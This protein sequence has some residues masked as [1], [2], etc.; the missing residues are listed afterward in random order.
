MTNI[1][2]RQKPKMI[3]PIVSVADDL[4]E[5]FTEAQILSWKSIDNETIDNEKISAM[6]N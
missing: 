6:A 5:I 2:K 1:H 3:T 4:F